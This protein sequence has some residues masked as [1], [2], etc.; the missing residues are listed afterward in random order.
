MNNNKTIDD[1]FK[2]DF[3]KNS[4][5]Y[6]MVRQMEIANQE[7]TKLFRLNKISTLL[8]LGGTSYFGYNFFKRRDLNWIKMM[9]IYN[10]LAFFVGVS[11]NQSMNK[12]QSKKFI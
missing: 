1:K 6:S 10:F 4:R 7:S 2:I 5:D 8:I 11:I 9:M 3:N 12:T